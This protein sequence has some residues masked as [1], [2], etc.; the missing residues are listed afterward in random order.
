MRAGGAVLGLKGGGNTARGRDRTRDVSFMRASRQGR[1]E[2]GRQLG[3][4][5]RRLRERVHVAL[6]E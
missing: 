3:E 2:R 5:F 1:R 6:Y 4:R